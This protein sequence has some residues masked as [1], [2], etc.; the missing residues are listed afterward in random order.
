[1]NDRVSSAMKIKRWGMNGWVV[2]RIRVR[3]EEAL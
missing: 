3:M 2:V 1:M